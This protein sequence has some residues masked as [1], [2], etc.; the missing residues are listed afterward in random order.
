MLFLKYYNMKFAFCLKVVL[1]TLIA[2]FAFNQGF[3]QQSWQIKSNLQP[4]SYNRLI[5]LQNV[6][7]KEVGIN[8]KRLT[9]VIITES[10]LFVTS[11]VG[12]YQL[13]YRDYPQSVFHF[14]ND[15]ANWLQMDKVGHIFTA[16]YLGKTGYEALRWCNVPEKKSVWYGGTLGFIYLLTIETLDGF[17]KEWGSSAGDL[18]ANIS[19]SGLF[20]GQQLLWKEQRIAMKFSFHQTEYPDYRPDLYGKRYIHNL[21]KDYNGQTYWLSLNLKSF[22]KESRFLPGW[23]NVAIGY[24]GEGM[25]GPADNP[26]EYEGPNTS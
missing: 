4:V 21:I 20:I 6:D 5:N 7:N 13:W 3:S 2:M 18:I 1:F 22:W 16:Y 9:G 23:L 25:T 19:G 10:G 17:S 11:M 15:N 14:A 8:K 24:S 26:T 12:L